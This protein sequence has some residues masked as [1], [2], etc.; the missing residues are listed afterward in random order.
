MRGLGGRWPVPPGTLGQPA[1]WSPASTLSPPQACREFTMHVTN[2]LQEQSRI[3]PV[4]PA[5]IEH[6]VGI[7]HGKFHSIQMQLPE[8]ISC[9]IYLE[10]IVENDFVIWD[11]LILT[12]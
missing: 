4:S 10:I 7:I 11:Y 8:G 3:R 9:R 2:L 12:S 6:M 1:R 5:E